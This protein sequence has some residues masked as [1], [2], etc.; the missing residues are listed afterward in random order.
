MKMILLLK[1]KGKIEFIIVHQLKSVYFLQTLLSLKSDCLLKSM[2]SYTAVSMGVV[3]LR[4]LTPA[5]LKLCPTCSS[6]L[7]WEHVRNANS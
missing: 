5:V 2:K 6:S 1:L 4:L 3:W 7:A